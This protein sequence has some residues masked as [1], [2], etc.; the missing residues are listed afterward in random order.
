MLYGDLL[1]AAGSVALER[2]H[3]T[4][5]GARK[6][7]KRAYGA[8]LLLDGFNIRKSPG[9]CHDR[10]CMPAICAG[11]VNQ[12]FDIHRNGYTFGDAP[13]QRAGLGGF[14]IRAARSVSIEFRSE[15]S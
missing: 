12:L 10:L 11:L 2:L 3:L 6:F 7:I 13:R 9:K 4:Y 15:R 1:L 14:A 8:V 5:K